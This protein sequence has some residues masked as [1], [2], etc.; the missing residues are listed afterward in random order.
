MHIRNLRFFLLFSILFLTTIAVVAQKPIYSEVKVQVAD[1][2]DIQTL[3]SLGFDIDHYQGSISEGIRFFVT[4]A[5]RDI[6]ANVG[7]PYTVTIPDYRAAY[8]EMLLADNAQHPNPIKTSELVAA[9]FDLGSMGGF[10]TFAEVEAKLDEMR[11]DFPNLITAKESIG[12]TVEGRDI[13]MVKISD[14]P[15]IDEPEPAAH[16]DALHHAREPLSMATTINFMFYLLENYDTDAYVRFLVDNREIYF[17]PVVN[18]DGYVF[19][20]ITDPDGGGLWR[21]NRFPNAGG[22]FGVDLNRNYGFG[23]ATNNECSS[24]NPCSG[25]Y[26]GTEAFSEEESKAI[27]DLLAV[28]GARTAF[29][30][31]ST[32]GTYLM[33]YGFNATPPAFDIYSEW[34]SAFLAENDYSYGTTSQMLG[35]TSCGTTRDYM[36]SEDIYG[37]TP[38]IA[39]SGFWPP[40]STIFDLVAENVRPYLFQA[41]IAGAY[42]D[43]QSHTIIGDV[44]P[45]E[46]FEVVIAVKNIG[47]GAT[48]NTASVIVQ[49]NNSFVVSPTATSFGNIA[50][51]EV[52]DNTASPFQFEVDPAIDTAFFT[53][54]VTTIQDGIPNEQIEIPVFL[55]EKEVLFSDDAEDTAANWTATGNGT[56]LWG[57]NTDDSYSGSQSFGD[58]NDGNG[59]NDTETFFELNPSLNLSAISAPRVGFAYKHS[60]PGNDF[61]Q[62]QISTDNGTSWD[63]LREFNDN[64]DWNLVS[65]NLNSYSDFE[66]VKFRFRLLNDGFIPGDGFY[67]DDFEVSGYTSN[68]L[69]VSESA[70]AQV[71]ITPNPFTDA[72]S[73]QLGGLDINSIISMYDPLGRQLEISEERIGNRIQI[74]NLEILPSGIYF[75][76]I[77]DV[78]AGIKT[79][80]RILK[81]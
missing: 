67:F 22:C 3:A 71:K 13:W 54:S 19:N 14:N 72:L 65:L 52:K 48:A 35:Y 42:L 41:Y 20:E 28:T 12:T 79:V 16:F 55:G 66:T 81:Q 73:I 68:I 59:E 69:G 1:T 36:H 78:A 43:I 57:V 8:N 15:D 37:W 33:P 39:G 2:E 62:L 29:S 44:L 24:P 70:A 61:V 49:A 38:E 47:V 25:V 58:S 11:T 45:G 9:G 18:P 80:K 63:V 46:P 50:A 5:E 56:I 31:H 17:V 40:P 23:Y 64:E 74:E 34:A 27:R 75:L 26:R 6:L 77:E 4:E 76:T 32:A 21:K 53:I 30:T 7:F 10:Y 51:R 60:L